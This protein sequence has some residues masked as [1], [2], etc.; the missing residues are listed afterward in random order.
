[1]GELA[2]NADTGSVLL[3]DN[4]LPVALAR[5][6]DARGFRSQHVNDLGLSHAEDRA[7]WNLAQRN[8]WVI[9]SKDEDFQD[10]AIRLGPPPQLVWVR[11]GNCRK[12][13]LFETFDRWMTHIVAAL[14]QGE[15]IIEL[16]G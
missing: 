5:H 8:R 16:R 6:L 4:Q 2:P 13:V 14:E 12:P 7:I 10:L 15:A 9:V 11:L 1:M 3:I